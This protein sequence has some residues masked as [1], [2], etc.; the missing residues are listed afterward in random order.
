MGS[1]GQAVL[2]FRHSMAEKVRRPSRISQLVA[3]IVKIGRKLSRRE[4]RTEESE[5]IEDDHH[6]EYCEVIDTDLDIPLDF[7]SQMKEAFCAFDKDKSGFI[8]SKEFGS[9]LRALG[10]NPTHAEVNSMMA[11]VDVDHNGKL[12]LT[13]FIVMMHNHNLENNMEE[14]NI[15]EMK[16]AFRAFDTDGDGKVSKDEVK[17]CLMN[18]GQDLC[19]RDIGEMVKRHDA[20]NDGFLEFKEFVT[21]LS[22]LEN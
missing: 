17:M 5:V 4:E 8:C 20:D 12:D 11:Q 18:F 21:L 3:P 13:E 1:H 19:D 6:F 2:W 9:I 7:V 16:M 14:E 15:E 10:R 22:N